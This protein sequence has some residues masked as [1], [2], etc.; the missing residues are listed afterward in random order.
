[1]S[2]QTEAKSGDLFKWALVWALLIA[3]VVANLYYNNVASAIKMSVGIVWV[4]VLLLIAGQTA[5]GHKT[6]V[7]IK[8]S[9]AEMLKVVWPERPQ[10][11][12]MSFI[13]VIMIVIVSLLLWGMDSL[14]MYGVSLLMGQGG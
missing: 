14:L 2:K 4:I 11:V 8:N 5:K 9:R 12:Q 6:R 1:M 3:G 13:V 7:F 10:I